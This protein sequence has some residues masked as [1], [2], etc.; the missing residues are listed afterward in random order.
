MSYGK[1]R[2]S[3][4][5]CRLAMGEQV[6]LRESGMRNNTDSHEAELPFQTHLRDRESEVQQALLRETALRFMRTCERHG[7]EGRCHSIQFFSIG[8]I[9]GAYQQDGLIAV[10]SEDDIG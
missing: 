2:Q 1:A 10:D 3:Q 6:R 8:R 5:D 7:R 9:G 4:A